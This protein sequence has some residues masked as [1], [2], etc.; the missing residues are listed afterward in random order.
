MGHFFSGDSG[1]DSMWAH[2]HHFGLLFG[3]L[4]SS[5]VS[6]QILG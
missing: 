6:C 5:G 1:Q 3:E 4:F 2:K